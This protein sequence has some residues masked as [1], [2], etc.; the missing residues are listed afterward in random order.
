MPQLIPGE[1]IYIAHSEATRCDECG[2]RDYKFGVALETVFSH[3]NELVGIEAI[4]R[5]VVCGHVVP[6]S[7]ADISAVA[8]ML[9]RDEKT[10]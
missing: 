10:R 7:C 2:L 3:D 4:V 6:Q 8:N 1:Y 5:F 9:D